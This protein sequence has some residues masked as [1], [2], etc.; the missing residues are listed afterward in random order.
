MQDVALLCA[1][2][3]RMDSDLAN[4]QNRTILMTR[5]AAYA[6]QLRVLSD[7]QYANKPKTSR[8]VSESAISGDKGVAKSDD[9]NTAKQRIVPL[10]GI[11]EFDHDIEI[12]LR[13]T[14]H[15][16][17]SSSNPRAHR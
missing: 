12:Q 8:M 2:Y 9:A 6:D 4:S 10:Y 11:P 3:Q 16:N 5:S 17:R 14:H 1:A 7:E 15:R 13:R